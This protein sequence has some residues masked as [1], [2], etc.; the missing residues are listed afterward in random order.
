MHADFSLARSGFLIK[1]SGCTEVLL[2]GDARRTSGHLQTIG[3][4]RPAYPQS[5]TWL[6]IDCGLSHKLRCLTFFYLPRSSITHNLLL[7]S[8]SSSQGTRSTNSLF[9]P[10]QPRKRYAA[11][12]T[13]T[14]N[15]A[16]KWYFHCPALC[17]PLSHI[18]SLFGISHPST[19]I[20]LCDCFL[21]RHLHFYFQSY[22]VENANSITHRSKTHDR[23]TARL[24][25][26][27]ANFLNTVGALEIGTSFSLVLFGIV[28]M[29]T[30]IYWR[31]F[32][33]D[34][35]AFKI[36]VRHPIARTFS[37]MG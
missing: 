37:L 22:L 23:C 6:K 9:S 11:T 7:H 30:Y 25:H 10:C 14:V 19:Y 28:T 35:P 13:S 15:T 16:S 34:R 33:E 36:L 32:E 5:K 31:R 20:P 24:K 4:C 2:D 17:Y 21:R 3:D 12:L 26:T 8:F 29:Q 18:H 1:H 27:M